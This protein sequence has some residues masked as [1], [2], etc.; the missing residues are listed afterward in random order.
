[1]LLTVTACSGNSDSNV[2]EPEKTDAPDMENSN[3]IAKP[4][5]QVVEKLV[6]KRYAGFFEGFLGDAIDSKSVVA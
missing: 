6:A 4:D 2:D 3:V 1:M 5:A